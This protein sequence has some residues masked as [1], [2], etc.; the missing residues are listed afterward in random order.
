MRHSSCKLDEID[1]VRSVELACPMESPTRSAS[2]LAVE[3]MMAAWKRDGQG[4]FLLQGTPGCGKSTSSRL[5]TRALGS[6]TMLFPSFDPTTPGESLSDMLRYVDQNNLVVI[7]IEEFDVVLQ[8]MMDKPV[9]AHKNLRIEVSDKAS[10]NNMLDA[11]QFQ[12]RMILVLTTNI[13]DDALRKLDEGLGGGLLRS[14][15]ITQW[16][17]FPS[18]DNPKKED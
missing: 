13:S 14:G 2:T 6:N 10:W 15:R 9:R 12:S 16:I 4:R 1:Y 18:S 5:L 8:K 7:V 11:L 3:Q 17:R